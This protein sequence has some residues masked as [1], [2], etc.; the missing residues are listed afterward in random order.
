MAM[1]PITSEQELQGALA[2]SHEAP[3]V[4]IFSAPWCG[5]C[6]TYKPLLQRLC[7]ERDVRL[8][9]IDA[10]AQRQL[11]GLYNVR[12]VPTTI[13]LKGGAELG[14][15]S[16]GLTETAVLHLFAKHA[17]GQVKLEF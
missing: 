11:A 9:E 5:P 13:V 3:V 8:Y 2:A 10:D 12:A 6:K 4:L 15:Q 16:G 17:V 1:T 14:R 7:T